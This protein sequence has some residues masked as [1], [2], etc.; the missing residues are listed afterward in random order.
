MLFPELAHF[1][2]IP[3]LLVL[4]AL[5]LP[6]SVSL[7]QESDKEDAEY[8][9]TL[10][11]SRRQEVAATIQG[12]PVTRQMLVF[13][14]ES[15]KSGLTK[16]EIYKKPAAEL[17]DLV[18]AMALN[19]IA[20]DHARQPG[21]GVGVEVQEMARRK[22]EQVVLGTFYRNEIQNQMQEPT[23]EEIQEFY[24]ANTESFSVPF[25]FSIRH[26][27]V[28]AYES[29]ETQEGDTLEG[30]AE[31]IGGDP[32]L[33]ERILI[34]NDAKSPRAPGYLSGD[35]TAIKPLE[36]GEHLLVPLSEE[37]RKA[38]RDR[39]AEARQRL[40]AGD[41]FTSVAMEYSD[42]ATKGEVIQGIQQSGRPVLPAILEAVE[43]TPEGG[44]TDIFETRHGYNIMAV[45]QKNP[46]RVKPL[47]EVRIA[48]VQNLKQR[49]R[50]DLIRE[51]LEKIYQGPEL[52]VDYATFKDPATSPGLTVVRVGDREFAKEGFIRP[53]LGETSKEMRDED[54]DMLVRNHRDLA[55]LL[56][57]R[58]AKSLGLDES[59][60]VLALNDASANRLLR[61][62]W[63]K[64]KR[65]EIEKELPSA[66]EAKAYFEKHRESFMTPPAYTFYALALK[67]PG[68]SQEGKDPVA[69]TKARAAELLQGVGAS[70][71]FQ[72]VAREHSDDM[73]G[74]GE[75]ALLEN[76]RATDLSDAMGAELAA[77]GRGQMGRP[78]FT[79]GYVVVPWLVDRLEPRVPEYEEVREMLPKMVQ[80]VK[81]ARFPEDLVND[82][83]Q[84]ADIQI[85]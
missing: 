39:I 16:K 37:G 71:E 67:V 4:L 50:D 14:N 51:M 75:D 24:G 84:E 33:V 44:I 64:A 25:T 31:R 11:E 56:W 82:L 23:E 41:S 52:K 36:P 85:Q 35:R 27:F 81:K 1:K 38:K 80:N 63:L 30:I 49:K 18:K 77:L 74:L 54:V 20:A 65:D 70:E 55:T 62:S 72:R 17:I 5:A 29:V 60:E 68:E 34:D 43:S 9:K 21:S 66:Q 47:E 79:N 42:N 61:D 12:K 3:S 83:L 6:W 15:S 48:I 26:I 59:P 53:E 13:F 45:V 69:E 46:E 57:F 78:I 22:T 10:P 58:F 2:K 73:P 19:R 76:A 28:S 40:E 7:A 8:E 32:A